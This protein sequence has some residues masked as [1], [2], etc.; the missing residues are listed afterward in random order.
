MDL[1]P[2]IELLYNFIVAYGPFLLVMSIIIIDMVMLLKDDDSE[3][4]IELKKRLVVIFRPKESNGPENRE[5]VC[6]VRKFLEESS[7]S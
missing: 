5:K 1:S 6:S 7:I 3:E 4:L 2:I